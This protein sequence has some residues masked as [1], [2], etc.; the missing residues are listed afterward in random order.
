M[1]GSPIEIQ[2]DKIWTEKIQTEE[3]NAGRHSMLEKDEFIKQLR[4]S[5]SYM[6]THRTIQALKKD[7]QWTPEEMK[8]LINIAVECDQVYGTLTYTQNSQVGD[9]YREIL[10]DYT[11]LVKDKVSV[12]DG[13]VKKIIRKIW[14]IPRSE[15]YKYLMEKKEEMLNCNTP[16]YRAKGW[17]DE[18][19]G[20][21]VTVCDGL[22]HANS[23][24]TAITYIQN[25]MLYS[26]QYGEDHF[27]DLQTPQESDVS[28][29]KD[30]IY[31]D[32]FFDNCD[33]RSVSGWQSP[34]GPVVF[35]LD[36]KVLF[37]PP[38]VIRITKVNPGST[39]REPFREMPYE[40]R[41]Y[42]SI[43][44]LRGTEFAYPFRT[45][46][47]HHTTMWNKS[48]L[49]LN[50]EVLKYILLDRNKDE[51]RTFQVKERLEKELEKAGLS[52]IPVIIRPTFPVEGIKLAT[53]YQN[54]WSLPEKYV[55]RIQSEKWQKNIRSE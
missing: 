35:V 41:Y 50:R 54:L 36:E 22:Y 12:E 9:F 45:V 43:D 7:I 32:L 5:T 37:D 13:N 55:G 30:G 33:I 31:N 8:E 34:Y 25:G 4:E 48:D 21:E 1:T 18:E 23:L 39:K 20:M 44:E 38:S 6:D 11:G 17:F 53:S 15:I 42:T 46:A 26:R 16:N 52:D 29:K 14:T 19:H 51:E 28:D 3:I 47:Y 2:T 27:S 24:S 10:R 49:L 40:E